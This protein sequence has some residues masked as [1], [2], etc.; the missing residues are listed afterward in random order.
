MPD[1]RPEIVWR[2]S[3]A[4]IAAPN[5]RSVKH[6]NPVQDRGAPPRPRLAG[7]LAKAGAVDSA[8]AAA[9]WYL[10]ATLL[11]MWPLLP[12]IFRNI[13]ADLGDPL[14]NCWILHWNADHFLRLLSGDLGA[15]HGF[16][17]AGIF[18]PSPLA[19]AYS[20]HLV[21]QALE[22][23]PIYAVTRNIVFCYNLLFLST[24]VLSGLGV[25]LLARSLT[26][27]ARAAFV[28]GLLF[29][30]APYRLAQLSHV[31]VL[32]TQW[33]ALSLYGLHRFFETRR[34]QALAG[35]AAALAVQ[36][37]SCGYF[38]LFFAPF[39][40]AFVAWEVLRRRLAGDWKLLA[41]LAGAGVAVGLATWPFL[42][43]YL[44]LRQLGYGARTFDEVDTFSANVLAYLT[45]TRWLHGWGRLFDVFPAPEGQLFPGFV[46]LVLAT[47]GG[48]IAVWGAWAGS[49]GP[50]LPRWRRVLSALAAAWA[51]AQLLL[52]VYLLAG[53]SRIIEVG[54]FELR[55]KDFSRPVLLAVVSAAAF[56]AATPRV[57]R[58]AWELLA[59]WG[60]WVVAALA[61]A[62]LS[63]G[64]I[65]R[66][67]LKEM[68]AGPYL[69]LYRYVPGFDGLR[70][71]ARF[72]LLVTLMLAVLAAFALDRLLRASRR[73]GL[74]TVAIVV[75]FVSECLPA[76][77]PIDGTGGT[78]SLRAPAPVRQGANVPAVYRYLRELPGN[79]PVL[80][81][82]FGEDAYRGAVRLLH[83]R[84]WAPDRERLQRHLPAALHEAATGHRPRARV[85]AALGSAHRVR[86]PDCRST[87]GCLQPPQRRGKDQRVAPVAGRA[88]RGDVRRGQG[89]PAAV[90]ETS[91]EGRSPDSN[92][93]GV[94][95]SSSFASL[96]ART[97][98]GHS[99][100]FASV[101]ALALA[102]AV[103]I[104]GARF[105][106]RTAAGSDAYGY[107]SQADLWLHGNLHV[108]QPWVAR[109][110]WPDADA[111]FAPLAYRPGTT[112]HT[113]VPTYPP[114]LPLLMAA[115]SL[116]GAHGARYL[117]VPLM[118]ALGVW[119]TWRLG[120]RALGDAGGLLSA[121][122]LASS[123]AFLFQLMLP[124]SDI[125]ATTAWLA[126]AVLVL[127]APPR[128]WLAGLAA[129]AAILIRPNLAPLAAVLTVAI[130]LT[131]ADATRSRSP[132][133]LRAWFSASA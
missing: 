115:F 110:A 49:R 11:L 104:L 109:F 53:G 101:L 39:A 2:D 68:S 59:G 80:E 124:M 56:V 122:L 12:G 74:I 112:P 36:N 125:P 72:G 90:R 86:R 73:S 128:P 132:W 35:A 60:F 29:A 4:D 18:Y 130:L 77:I 57:R 113:L 58:A 22:I 8:W 16:W 3:Q 120:R 15:L 6:E 71:P 43:P 23:L 87:R 91:S 93:A 42:R 69:L 65:I 21:P 1:F 96:L 54:S 64:P 20:E 7:A 70:V 5:G 33:M 46:L 13:P 129:C 89:I 24:F 107:V 28:A 75:L 94:G 106:S 133:F 118:A 17:N 98:V 119:L 48:A 40:A 116:P 26:G 76:P 95:Q 38:L 41:S 114:G 117:V 63:L 103:F 67:G 84:A 81:F 34:W 52:V 31:Q 78:E 100:S 108:D 30:F 127:C 50:V 44:A 55:L 27:N 126:A 82:P 111:V 25:Y 121:L 105:G 19:L 51:A 47:A 88:P 32:S 97:G 92:L 14:L 131:P 37:L 45:G 85:G 123:P 62:S 66:T 61:A 9:G 10:A 102:L 99:S 79:E 83:D